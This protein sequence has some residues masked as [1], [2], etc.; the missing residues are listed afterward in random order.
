MIGSLATGI[1]LYNNNYSQE[2]IVDDSDET[3]EIPTESTDEYDI[4]LSNALMELDL[5]E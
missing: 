4:N 3:V 1:Y 5:V 2:E